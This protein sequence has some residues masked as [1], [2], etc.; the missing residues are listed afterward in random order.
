MEDPLFLSKKEMGKERPLWQ[1]VVAK[2][3]TTK[4]YWSCWDSH[5]VRDDVLF[6]RWET[7][8]K[9]IGFSNRISRKHVSQI[10]KEMHNSPNK[11]T[12]WC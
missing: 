10:L 6:K 12:F 4:V 5:E 9:K 8:L 3:T 7:N 11:E 2:D 1:E